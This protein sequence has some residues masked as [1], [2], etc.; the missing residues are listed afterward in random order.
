MKENAPWWPPM[1][2]RRVGDHEFNRYRSRG[3]PKQLPHFSQKTREMGHP[4]GLSLIQEVL[5]IQRVP[6]GRAEPRVADDAAQLLFCGAVGH[7]GGAD[8]VFFQHH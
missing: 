2:C 5:P 8:Y 3:K 1:S 6:L 4:Y 7:A